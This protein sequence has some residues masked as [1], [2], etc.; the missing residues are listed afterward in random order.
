MQAME[1]DFV[2]GYPTA[3]SPVAYDWSYPSSAS[4]DQSPTDIL[5]LLF[6]S[7]QNSLGVQS[8]HHRK[9]SDSQQSQASLFGNTFSQ[10][11]SV[12]LSG[13]YASSEHSDDFWTNEA[14]ATDFG[15]FPSDSTVTD[16]K[17]MDR[18]HRRRE[19][20]RKAQS[21]FRQKRKEEVRRLEQEVEELRAQ[22]A[23]YHKRG[24]TVAL[25][26]CT[27]CRNFFPTSAGTAM[28]HS[29]NSGAFGSVESGCES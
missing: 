1:Q 4:S 29:P 5:D 17:M 21:N 7:A 22:I 13:G 19:Q 18:K 6:E 2:L 27:R 16:S 24:P 20:N 14:V 8:S 11:S 12:D 26:I 28:P 10:P 3:F 25:T 15:D 9:E 23:G